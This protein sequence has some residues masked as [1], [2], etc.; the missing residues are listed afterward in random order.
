MV[1]DGAFNIVEEEGSENLG[2]L[3]G[4]YKHKGILIIRGGE[5]EYIGTEKSVSMSL[6][7]EIHSLRVTGYHPTFSFV[8]APADAGPSILQGY[9]LQ[10]LI[11]PRPVLANI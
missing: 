3:G 11:C 5:L 8:L 6:L 10:H 9:K 1:G 7:I 2:L 4:Y